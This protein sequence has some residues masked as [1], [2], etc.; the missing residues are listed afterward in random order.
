MKPYVPRTTA[1]S[2]DRKEATKAKENRKRRRRTMT[3]TKYQQALDYFRDLGDCSDVN[4]SEASRVLG[5]ERQTVSRALDQGWMQHNPPWV[6]IKVMIA[7]E[8]KRARAERSDLQRALVKEA[9][10]IAKKAQEDA[11]KARAQEGLLVAGV[12]GAAGRLLQQS[13]RLIQ[14]GDALA[15]AI[16]PRLIR[17]A[18]L[19]AQGDSAENR[20]SVGDVLALMERF[21][22]F[23]KGSTQMVHEAMV[24]ERKFL[25]EAEAVLGVKSDM[26]LHEAISELA[27]AHITLGRHDGG[28]TKSLP[29]DTAQLLADAGVPLTPDQ[30]PV[31]TNADM[32]LVDANSSD[33]D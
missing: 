3:F 22:G 16:E 29:P 6:P 4:I 15:K 13:V 10:S 23:A 8:Q 27:A 1:M 17:I 26:D 24:L 25:G 31:D 28:N 18:E 14:T 5:L 9:A 33:M 7:D 20:Q 32:E 19:A 21:L 11:I 30:M 12:R 2:E